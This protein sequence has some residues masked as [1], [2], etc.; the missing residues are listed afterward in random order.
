VDLLTA[1]EKPAGDKLHDWSERGRALAEWFHDT[2]RPADEGGTCAY[3]D[4]ILGAQSLATIDHWVPNKVCPPLHL[5]WGNLFPA[6]NG[7]N[8]AKGSKWSVRWLRP[9]LDDVEALIACDLVT[10]RLEPAAEVA[11]DDVRRRIVETIEGID[12]NRPALARE[13]RRIHWALL[14]GPS[15][16]LLDR[17]RDEPYRFLASY[18]GRRRA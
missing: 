10:G 17:A 11:D 18:L 6:C 16:G 2:V 3:C 8:T 5:W 13:R 4:G 7:C 12:L 9:D 1:G 14:R 15:E